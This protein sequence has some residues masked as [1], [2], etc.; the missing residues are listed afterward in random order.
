ME[1]Q[2]VQMPVVDHYVGQTLCLPYKSQ[3]RASMLL[4]YFA[5]Q[6]RRQISNYTGKPC[7]C[8]WSV[9]ELNTIWTF[10]QY[11]PGDNLLSL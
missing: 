2:S 4:D 9:P 5:K 11:L 10:P 7:D 6:W 3:Q 8:L 1:F